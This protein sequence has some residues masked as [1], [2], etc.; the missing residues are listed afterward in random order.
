M[1]LIRIAHWET[2]FVDNELAQNEVAIALADSVFGP[3]AT[4]GP[5]ESELDGNPVIDVDRQRVGVLMQTSPASDKIIGYS[6]PTNCLIALDAAGQILSVA[7]L[8]SGDT[9]DHVAIVLESQPF[10]TSFQGLGFQSDEE[11]KNVDAVSGATLTSY[12]VIA[13]VANRLGGSAP[14]L[15]FEAQPNLENVQRLFQNASSTNP[16]PRNGV[17]T[18]LDS[19]G[20][21]LGSVL[22]TTPAADH[23]S[24]YQGP[25]VVLMAFDT[26]Q[27]CTGMILDQTYDNQPYSSYL[28]DDYGFQSFYL[29]RTLEELAKLS[30]DELGIEGVSGATMT[31]MSVAEG[32]PLAAKAALAIPSVD[33]STRRSSTR[34]LASYLLD[35]ITIVLATIGIVISVTSLRNKKWFRIGY[36]FAVVVFLGFIGGHLLS[37]A[38]LAGWAAH[39]IPWTTAPGLVFLSFAALVVP[40]VSKHQ[41][42]CHHICP[43]GSLQQLA[44]NRLPWKIRVSSWFRRLLGTIPWL[45]LFLVVIVSIRS[46]PINLASIEPFDAF[47]FRVAGWASIS[48][49]VIGLIGSLFV[50]MAY[51]R[52]GCPTGA[53]LNYLKFRADSGRFG[54]RDFAAVALLGIGSVLVAL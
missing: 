45:L 2:E 6:G 24:G 16:S 11:W 7:I 29:G 42:Y 43:F 5:F 53:V 33:A 35:L 27:R 39:S 31:S 34:P 12:A 36:Q 21:T 3:S 4:I 25:S 46:I 23:L 22:S 28:D 13:S 17:W 47:A 26:S 18:V 15:K 30:P 38:S 8:S 32:I 44:R 14:S 49:F 48:I 40:M 1:S 37:Q 41:P 51:C 52:F 10:L 54:L 19:K 50:P 20:E 9:L